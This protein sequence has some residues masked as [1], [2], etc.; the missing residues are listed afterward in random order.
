MLSSHN[1][2]KQSETIEEET[3][4]KIE[5]AY[6]IKKRKRVSQNVEMKHKT[7]DNKVDT[8]LSKGQKEKMIDFEHELDKKKIQLKKVFK[9]ERDK[10]FAELRHLREVILKKAREE[11]EEVK[12]EAYQAGLKEGQLDGYQTGLENG[13]QEGIEKAEHLKKNS[14]KVIEQA[15]T[16]MERYQK[17]K[18]HEF[19]EL[20][21]IMAETIINREL[22]LSDTELEFL[23][24]PILNKLEKIDN[25]I[26]VFVTKEN[27]VST[28]Q[29]MKNLKETYSDLKYAVLVDESLEKNGCVIETSYE[30]IDLQ[31]R[32]QLD[33]MVKDLSKE[34]YHD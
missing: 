7:A 18:Q 22:T 14:L 26:S 1:F 2:Y 13:Y 28:N 9:N 27:Q 4:K 15:K 3:V 33:V 23:L 12:N 31:L 34:D 21:S 6:T 32:K 20:A 30:V 25:F 10:F 24:D 29:Y 11:A 8:F 19:I 17:E 16:E 5:T